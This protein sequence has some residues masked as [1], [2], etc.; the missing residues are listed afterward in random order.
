[1]DIQPS[2]RKYVY[3]AVCWHYNNLLD[4]NMELSE[5][6]QTCHAHLCLL[7]YDWT[8]GEGFN[9]R[10]IITLD[11]FWNHKDGKLL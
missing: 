1:M 11:E 4:F 5:A 6:W 8:M 2:K 10:S 7:S 3:L 9:E